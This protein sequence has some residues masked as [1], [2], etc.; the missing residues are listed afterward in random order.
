[1]NNSI[2]TAWV[3][4]GNKISA[5]NGAIVKNCGHNPVTTKTSTDRWSG[6]NYSYIY[7]TPYWTTYEHLGWLPGDINCDESVFNSGGQSNVIFG[8][9]QEYGKSVT[10]KYEGF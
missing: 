9:G 4:L 1:M 3:D 8:T 7:A 10:H 6:E 2:P 5:Y